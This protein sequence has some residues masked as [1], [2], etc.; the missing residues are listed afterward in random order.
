M[1]VDAEFKYLGDVLNSGGDNSA[2]MKD[3][4]GKAV[5]TTN[6]II[7]LSKQVNFGKNQ[8]SNLLLL[9]RSVFIPWLTCNCET[10]TNVTIKGYASLRKSQLSFLRRALENPRSFPTAALYLELSILPVKREIKIKQLS[11]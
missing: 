2:M 11:F 8:I 10:W 1:K 7:S 6:E 3:R 5:G 4:V 9:C